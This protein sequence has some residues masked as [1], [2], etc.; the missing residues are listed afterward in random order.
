[1]EESVV[2]EEDEGIFRD[3]VEPSEAAEFLTTPM[4]GLH[5]HS[6]TIGKSDEEIRFEEYVETNLV[7]D[8]EARDR[9]GRSGGET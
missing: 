8:T 3:E 1:M 5:E 4:N 2:N 9:E 7:P 6:V